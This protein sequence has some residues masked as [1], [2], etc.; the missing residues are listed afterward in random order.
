[1]EKKTVLGGIEVVY[2]GKSKRKERGG[3]AR[4]FFK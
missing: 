2:E 4:I 1:M 3:N